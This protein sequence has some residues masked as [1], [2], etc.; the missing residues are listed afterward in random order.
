MK[1]GMNKFLPVLVFVL[2][3][4]RGGAVS[5]MM[6]VD[7]D[8]RELHRQLLHARLEIPAE[9]GELTLL[10]PKW[11]PGTHAPG[12]PIANVAGLRLE[13]IDGHAISWRRDELD[14]FQIHC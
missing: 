5:S 3:A 7:V 13:T 12:G 4:F 11:I 9:P 1:H 8:A 2:G 14:P 6:R 10:Y